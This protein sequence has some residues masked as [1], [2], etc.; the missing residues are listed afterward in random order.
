MDHVDE[1]SLDDMK[2][3]RKRYYYNRPLYDKIMRNR[4]P[5]LVYDEDE[6]FIRDDEITCEADMD[7]NYKLEED[8]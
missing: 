2:R 1:C 7:F 8:Q 6:A 3:M 5:E 4:A